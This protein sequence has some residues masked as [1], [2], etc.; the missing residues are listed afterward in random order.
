M[1]SLRSEVLLPHSGPPY[2]NREFDQRL[3]EAEAA[4]CVDVGGKSSGKGYSQ[5]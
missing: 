4:S 1:V 2:S 5:R 3:K